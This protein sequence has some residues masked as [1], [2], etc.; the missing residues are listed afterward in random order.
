MT[1]VASPT[2]PIGDPDRALDCEE[3]LETALKHLSED[4]TLREEDIE[5]QLMQGG[6]AAGWEE[7]ELQ[8]AIADLRRNA[9]LGLQGLS[10]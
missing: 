7:S 10:E 8:T 4:D 9:A 2:R 5:A 6:L 3:A 1:H